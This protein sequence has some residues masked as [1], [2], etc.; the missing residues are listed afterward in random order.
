MVYE[1]CIFFFSWRDSPLVGL[2]LLI[3][4]VCFSRSHTTMHHS[5]DSSGRVIS[6]L[7]RP[8][9]DNTQHS[10][11]TDIHAPPVGFEPIISKGERL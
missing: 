4:E 8:L 2:G 3:H 5:Q 10:Q 7:Q 11:Q 6:S 1:K 9:P